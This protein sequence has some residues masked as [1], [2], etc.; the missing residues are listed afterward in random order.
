MQMPLSNIAQGTWSTSHTS[1]NQYFSPE[2]SRDATTRKNDNM[3]C[4]H[5]LPLN[6]HIKALHI[7]VAAF[8]AEASIE[9]NEAK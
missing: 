2:I 1:T 3:K 9:V 4:S 5:P 7:S 8:G 6:S